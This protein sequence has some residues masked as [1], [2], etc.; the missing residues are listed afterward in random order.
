MIKLTPAI[1]V[2]GRYDKNK[3]SQIFDTTVIEVGGF[4][5]FKD[6]EK[7]DMLRRIAQ[8]RGIVVLTDPDGAGL[9]IRNRIKSCI[10]TGKVYHAY[11]PDIEGKEKRKTKQ[12]KEG[13]LGVE[14]VSDELIVD[15]VRKSGAMEETLSADILL[16][17]ELMYELGLSGKPDS[18]Q[19]RAR[20][21]LELNL[22][23]NLSANALMDAVNAL[24]SDPDIQAYINRMKND[25][26]PI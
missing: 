14:G 18:K 17:K 20:M 15:A 16:T 25:I 4:G 22:P 7:T 13:L 8:T 26:S 11:I 6:K 12:S 5:L 23:K 19:A 10:S 3:V 1:V 2:E 9:V 24:A 21:I